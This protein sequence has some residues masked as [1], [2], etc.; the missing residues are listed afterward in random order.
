[1]KI[2]EYQAKNIFSRYGIPIPEG[3]VAHTP[4]EAADIAAELGGNAVVKAQVHAGG[5]GKAGRHQGR[6]LSRRGGGGG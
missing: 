2:H 6:Q 5:R 4:G 3:K 1:M